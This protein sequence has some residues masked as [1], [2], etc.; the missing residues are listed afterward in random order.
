MLLSASAILLTLLLQYAPRKAMKLVW[1]GY[2]L[3]VIGG[4][5][6]MLTVLISQS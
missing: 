1:F 6:W 2:P 4:A 3:A 5:L